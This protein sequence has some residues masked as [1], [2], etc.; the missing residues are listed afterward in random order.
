MNKGNKNNKSSYDYSIKMMYWLFKL[1]WLRVLI[2]AETQRYM[3]SLTVTQRQA[4]FLVVDLVTLL[5]KMITVT[6]KIQY[7]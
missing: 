3:T 7:L 2:P 4:C 1:L 5:F 6:T